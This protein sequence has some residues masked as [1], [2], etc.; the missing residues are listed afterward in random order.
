MVCMHNV[1][2]AHTCSRFGISPTAIRSALACCFRLLSHGIYVGTR[3]CARHPEFAMFLDDERHLEIRANRDGRATAADRAY[4]RR[5]EVIAA[6]NA[7]RYFH[8]DDV[9]GTTSAAVV[10]GIPLLGLT[11]SLGPR[12]TR[13]DRNTPEFSS[14][15]ALGDP[16]TPLRI[17]V[18]NP[19]RPYRS[20]WISRRQSE[21]AASDMTAWDGLSMTTRLRTCID[22]ARV[23]TALDG[24]IA[25]DWV[26]A[27]A[28]K[29]GGSPALEQARLTLDE[30]LARC[31]GAPGVNRAREAA[32]SATGMA[33][34]VAESVAMRWFRVL[35][36]DPV[37]QQVVL[38][39][40]AGEHVARVDFIVTADDGTSVV[41]EV[42]GAVKYGQDAP[43]TGRSNALF[44]E[45]RRE[46][47]IRRLGY[48]VV[49]MTWADLMSRSRVR[50][51][52][53]EAGVGC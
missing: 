47:R 12:H 1:I 14:R 48:R 10:H 28:R 27:Q 16:G 21:L 40:H 6:I 33:E 22:L 32:A 30:A 41:V 20:A 43:E 42:D 2:T 3:K 34:S 9:L 25:T 39:N 8:P 13:R 24:A 18:W 51:L 45:K 52:L 50:R 36:V 49:R 19:Q 7:Y 29:D 46:D 17:E 26:L 4:I 5:C 15:L 44:R 38:R 53:H 37:R 11:M 23:G 35:G 31:A